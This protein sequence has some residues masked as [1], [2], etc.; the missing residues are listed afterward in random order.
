MEV[1]YVE[2]MVQ[3]DNKVT[4]IVD[5]KIFVVY[6]E[7]LACCNYWNGLN[8]KKKI[9]AAMPCNY[10][11]YCQKMEE[12]RELLKNKSMQNLNEGRFCAGFSQFSGYSIP[13]VFKTRELE[14]FMLWESKMIH[15][16][17]VKT[18]QL[19]YS[20]EP[21][22]NKV[23]NFFGRLQQRIKTEDSLYELQ[24]LISNHYF[25]KMENEMRKNE[26]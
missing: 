16:F 21:L 25:E 10:K 6:K 8:T 14:M 15:S 17:S 13:D 26:K 19:Q 7:A 18:V 20:E 12:Y 3:Y 9:I 4:S 24:K 23:Q 1:Y 2:K 11:E 5:D 22:Q